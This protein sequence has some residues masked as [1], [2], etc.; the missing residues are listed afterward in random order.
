MGALR[1]TLRA[2]L[3][4]RWRPMLTLALLLGITGGVVL[5][6]A[7]GA[8]RTDTAYPRLLRW[9]NAAQVNVI[10]KNTPVPAFFP[11]LERLPG[12]AVASAEG[13]FDFTLPA[14]HGPP[15]ALVETYSSPDDSMGRTGDRLKMVAGQLPD[16]ARPASA[17]IDQDLAAREHLRPGGTL[18]LLMIPN[19]KGGI[20]D[21]RH[22]RDMSFRVSGI[23]VFDSQIVPATK[24]NAEPTALLSPAFYHSAAA[25]K[26]TYGTQ[27]GVR[28][29]P[30]VSVASFARAAATLARRYPAT[31]GVIVVSL[32]D[33][34]AAT[35]RAIRPQAVA[36]AVFAALVALIALAVIGQLLS[37]QLSLDSAQYP[38]L[39]ALGMSRTA[40]AALSLA[41]L[42]LVTT[43]GAVLA[44]V[45][46]IAASPLMPI[47][48]ARLAEPHPGVDV[49]LAVL[50]AGLVLIAG[51]PLL[52]LAGAIWRNATRAARRPDQASPAGAGEAS[53]LGAALGRLG[54]VP[55]SIG[56]RMAF[57]AGHG[58]TAV[59]VRSA[60]AGTIVAVTS[61]VAALV[62]GASLIHLV[63]TPRLYGQRW[64]Q[65]LDLGFGGVPG[66][67]LSGILA[68]QPGLASY[69]I[70]NYG[71]ITVQGAIV[72][73]IGVSPVRGRDFLSL[74]AG[75]P[76][77]RP[78][79]IALGAQT[80]QTLHRRIG[81][82][83][84]VQV[85]GVTRPM[86]I[87][88]TA[89]FAAFSRGSFESTDLGN[90]AVLPAPVL[91]Q[92]ER[93][94][95]CPRPRTCYSFALL[96]YRPG[97]DLRTAA[98]RLT[99]MTTRS[100]CP[101]GSCLVI[102][103]Q[104]PDDI[105]NFSRVRD[106]PLI[107]GGVLALLAVGTLAHVLV[108]AVRRRRRDL[109]LLKTLGLV[110]RQ[111]LGVVEWQALSLAGVALL[112]GVPL[113]LLAG[114]WAWALFASSAGLASAASIPAALVLLVIPVTFALAA[115]IAA[116]PARAAAR[117]RPATVLRAE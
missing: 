88:G 21:L 96:R 80:L 14:R 41:R 116:W 4:R 26:S 107:L 68:R 102:S 30:G 70:G 83:I 67:L 57:E 17:V 58:R 44:V 77:A 13:L 94:T 111:V 25:A 117:V 110:R 99:A 84:A 39:S 82:R 115:L 101:I 6:A 92:P 105:R 59:P 18:H 38:V 87:T 52:L 81:Q 109:A 46:A 35:Q 112:A 36:L 27:A 71:D 113:G 62:F 114:R 73:A 34:A 95:G 75:R 55:G 53:R 2:E 3:R 90:G 12:V 32:Q 108:T 10:V 91:S 54:S 103:D 51:L 86:L 89:V 74:L 61:V 63:S 65:E 37:R 76:P 47:G 40:L 72:P 7:A 33:E 93:E 24:V 49:N 45:I 20:P 1:L 69:A 98:A 66:P 28:L 22:A 8:A 106:T 48:P 15:S 5:T 9:A 97:T 56:A 78:D 50:G 85:N 100:G 42:A 29:R 31:G 79:E 43:A 19:M 11:A 64:Q 60:L 16:P 104:R 23:A